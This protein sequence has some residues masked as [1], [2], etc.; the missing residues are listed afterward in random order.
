MSSN[1]EY[2]SPR[3]ERPSGALSDWPQ[4][5]LA[6]W[7]RLRAVMREHSS[8]IT[9]WSGGVDSTLVAFVAAQ[10]HADRALAVTGRSASLARE[11]RDGVTRLSA[12]LSLSHRFVW[13]EELKNENYRA[14][15]GDR[16]FYCKGELFSHLHD[17]AKRE[18][19]AAVYSGDSCD[20]LQDL[21]PGMDAARQHGVKFPLIEAGLGKQQIRALADQLGLPNAYKPAAPCLASRVP[22]GTP[23]D[24]PTLERIDRAEAAVRGLG[25]RIFRVR[26]HGELARLEVA[27]NEMQRAFEIREALHQALREVGYRWVALELAPFYSGSLNLVSAK[28][29]LRTKR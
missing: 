25:F 21:R 13:T 20:D 14:N 8:S 12:E 5:V 2:D 26:H 3:L 1:R 18:G 11:E 9:A 17:L 27:A 6:D 16:C 19:F 15:Q 22:V 10:V 4:E 29:L 23:V 7:Q 24:A 28:G